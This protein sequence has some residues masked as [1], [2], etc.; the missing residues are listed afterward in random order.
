[1]RE[2]LY[3]KHGIWWCRVRNPNGGRALRYSCETKDYEAALI[4]WR[5]LE[6]ETTESKGS[7]SRLPI[8]PRTKP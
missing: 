8:Q 7:P 6:R 1:M 3:Q 4:R 5:Q 2:P